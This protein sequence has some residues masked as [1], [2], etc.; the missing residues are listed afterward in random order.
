[1][2]DLKIASLEHPKTWRLVNTTSEIEEMVFTIQGILCAKDL[3]PL[4]Q[5]PTVQASRYR[6]LKQG[7]TITGLGSP[8]FERALNGARQLFG[9]F[10]CHFAEGKL[11]PWG[12]GTHEDYTALE[13]GNRYFTL[14]KD[15][16]GMVEVPFG[17]GVDS[18][19]ILKDM[20]KKGGYIHGEENVVV[21]FQ[22]HTDKDGT[23]IFR[24]AGPH[25]FWVGDLVEIQASFVVVPLRGDYCRMLGI[26][27]SMAL[28]D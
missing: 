9:L 6:F 25:I 4:S 7:I 5:R 24:T 19:G 23:R 12:M 13:F 20:A 1:D 11:E 15:A 21:Y 14:K 8:T 10:D 3:P 16:P 28:I 2:Y 22:Q 26:L 27:R 17:P 18:H